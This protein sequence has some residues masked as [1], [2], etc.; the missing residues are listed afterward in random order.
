MQIIIC[1]TNAN[2]NYFMII[3]FFVYPEGWLSTEQVYLFALMET[4]NLL[5][6]PKCNE[7]GL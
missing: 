7:R 6:S 1:Y 2:V 5:P 4:E 3:L